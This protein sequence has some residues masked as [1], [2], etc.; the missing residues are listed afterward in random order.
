MMDLRVM[1]III[2]IQ[3]S[4]QYDKLQF[5]VK[6]CVSGTFDGDLDLVF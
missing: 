2:D 6:F 4:Q 3:L 1:E 5:A